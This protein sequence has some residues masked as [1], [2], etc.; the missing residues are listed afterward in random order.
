MWE[1]EGEGPPSC[2]KSESSQ[3]IEERGSQKKKGSEKRVLWGWGIIN[4]CKRG[5]CS[6]FVWKESKFS[7]TGKKFWLSGKEGRSYFLRRGE[8]TPVFCMSDWALE[9]K[10]NAVGEGKGEKRYVILCCGEKKGRGWRDFSHC[11]N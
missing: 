7:S 10:R 9:K 8:K 6:F 4:T 11:H 3:N 5:D 2:Y 1:S